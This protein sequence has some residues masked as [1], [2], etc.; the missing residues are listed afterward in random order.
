VIG[1]LT[2]ALAGAAVAV[3]V[4]AVMARVHRERIAAVVAERDAAVGVA[5]AGLEAAERT[6]ARL[7]A[8]F[9]RAPDGVVVLD[10]DGEV[11]LRND[12][13]TRVRGARHADI[14]AEEAL[15]R[16]LERA[17][18]GEAA[19]RELQLFGPPR[20]VLH[21]RAFPLAR[22]DETLGAVAFVRDVTDTRRVESV[23]RDFV[24]N[25]SHELKT[26]IGALALLAE[27]IA[28]GADDPEM[29]QR[30]AE[31]VVREAD[32]L[33]NIVDDLLDLSL[34]E[35]QEAPTRERTPI[36]SVVHEAVDRV[37]HAADVAGVPLTVVEPIADVDVVCDARQ[38]CSA[39]VN[40]LENA[41]KYSDRGAPVQ[42]EARLDA[43]RVAV[44]VSDRGIGIPTR[45]LERIFERFDRV[46]RARSRQTGGTGLGL[47]IVRHVV[48]A[49]GGEVSVTSTEGEGST[50][51][52]HLPVEG[53]RAQLE[54]S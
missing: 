30:L 28:S 34:I 39:I 25:V 27:T 45:D 48:Q 50:F 7:H 40:L 10:R 36:E 52:V 24:A 6:T 21:V 14:L 44:V 12:A 37:R 33:G 13:A 46:D 35:A 38:L 31:R 42:V 26:P 1:V 15:T 18:G 20:Q 53:P 9:D 2:A 11:L 4:A 54:V 8:A 29:M 22:G 43:G 3:L 47:S 32:R 41:V 51:T 5:T 17:L 19:E 49:H 23:R 16:V